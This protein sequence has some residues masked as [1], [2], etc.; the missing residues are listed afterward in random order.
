MYTNQII[1]AFLPFFR[2]DGANACSKMVFASSG[3]R[4]ELLG[5]LPSAAFPMDRL[6]SLCHGSALEESAACRGK[7]ATQTTHRDHLPL[8]SHLTSQSNRRPC[9][10]VADP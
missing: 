8:V 1:K 4:T 5:E 2:D 9:G 6:M 10:D 7:S 3:F